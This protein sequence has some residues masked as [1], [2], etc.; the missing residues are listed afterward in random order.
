M[1]SRW[2]L[3][4]LPFL[5]LSVSASDWP[6]W[7]GPNR[8]GVSLERG[9][10]STWPEGGPK[11]LWNARDANKTDNGK[12]VGEGWSSLAIVG[13]RIYTMGDM[14]DEKAKKNAT[15]LVC[16]DRDT[17][18]VLW[19]T[20]AGDTRGGN[21]PRSTPTV[22][23]DRVYGVTNAGQLA[24]LDAEKGTIVWSKDYV[25]DFAGRSMASWHFCESPLIDGEKLICTPGGLEAGLIALDKK[26]G[27]V[28]WKSPVEDKGGA[29]YAS[30]MPSDGGGVHQ[31][32]TFMSQDKGLVGVDAK[33]GKLLWNYRRVANGTG[34]ISTVIVKGDLIFAST[35]YGTGSAL[36]KLLP[37]GAGGVKIQE[38]Y[39]LGGNKLQNHHGQLVRIGDYIY[40]GHGH[41]DGQPFCL[42]MESGKFA[43]GPERNHPG[44]G[45]AAV[46]AAGGDIYFRWEDNT[47]GLVEASPGG[48]VLK[49][50]FRLPNLGTGWQHPVVAG[51]KMYIRGNN[52]V[53]CYDIHSGK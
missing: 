8:D 34:N 3:L 31:Y 2:S 44:S 10:L 12:N 42:H 21:G 40:G 19:S 29:G 48:Y 47:M 6:Q 26:T 7:R 49:G 53:L 28:L 1:R 32:V 11:L 24:C 39:F 52:Q 22:D 41:G 37:D 20:K 14:R 15:F 51:G 25:K 9:L 50:E 33:T 5:A 13:K 46:I 36:L 4:L 30:I 18:K 17:G 27:E 16:L 45:S 35:G 23:G 38:K 43:W